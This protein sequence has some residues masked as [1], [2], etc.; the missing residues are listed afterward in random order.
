M[1]LDGCTIVL[2]AVLAA[3]VTDA[4]CKK[5]YEQE[6]REAA[7]AT[8]NAEREAQQASSA[9]ITSGTLDKSDAE[10]R[11]IAAEDEALREQA[12][13][14]ASLRREQLDY[15]G[16][17]QHAIDELD[18][19][20]AGVR[21]KI[22]GAVPGD[23][24]KTAKEAKEGDGAKGAA[25]KAPAKLDTQAKALLSRREIL[26]KDMEAIDRSTAEDWPTVKARLD[27]DLAKTPQITPRSDRPWGQPA[28]E[29][30][31][32]DRGGR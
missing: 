22:E 5:S 4:G 15:R 31:T 12:E 6:R 23:D 11:A 16:R 1:T 26:K 20:L 7:E 24:A 17:V 25:A 18:Q 32:P 21:Q 10:E 2:A 14:L 28:P 9:T 29:T 8:R 13:A 27:E 3:V 19:Q 30:T